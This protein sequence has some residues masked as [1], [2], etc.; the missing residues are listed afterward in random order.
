MCRSPEPA[1]VRSARARA[2]W[3][4]AAGIF[5][6]GAD[7]GAGPEERP[8]NAPEREKEEHP[9][10]RSLRDLGTAPRGGPLLE[11]FRDHAA[12]ST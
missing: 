11:R 1:P 12:K 6:A 5:K 3:R 4:G 2:A 10:P 9:R 7:E 8:A